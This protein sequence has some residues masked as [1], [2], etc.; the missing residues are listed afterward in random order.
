MSSNEISKEKIDIT[1]LVNTHADELLR[2]ALHKTNNREVA[3][4]LVQDTFLSVIQSVEK[5]RGESNTK[6]WLFSILNNKIIDYYRKSSSREI[7]I[8]TVQSDAAYTFTESFFNKNGAWSNASKNTEWG[9][10]MHLLDDEEF[11][12]IMEYC[13]DDLPENWGKAIR[14]KYIF[15]KDSKAICQ[16]LNISMSNYWQVVHRA[17]LLL[18]KCIEVNYFKLT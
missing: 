7:L 9:D 13:L 11:N 10:E 12:K 8:Q 16:D 17:K 5:F 4:D 3:E 2:W 15:D 1:R 14:Y 6:T 18:K